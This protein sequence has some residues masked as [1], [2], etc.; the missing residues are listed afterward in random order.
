[1]D[2]VP[3]L[4]PAAVG[5]ETRLVAPLRIDPGVVIGAN[6]VVGPN[7]YLERDC[8]IGA[9]VTLRDAVVLRDALVPDGV[10]VVEQVVG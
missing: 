7:V 5:A 1:M 2:G 4:Q 10:T 6:C 8:R 9:G 3:V